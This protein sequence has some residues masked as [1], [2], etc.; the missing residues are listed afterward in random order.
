VTTYNEAVAE[1]R[2]LVKR[3]EDDQWR[4]AELTWQQ[5]R[6]NGVTQRQ[7]AEDVGIASHSY[8]GAMARTWERFGHLGAQR[9]VFSEAMRLIHKPGE[10]ADME[11]YGS[12]HRAQAAQAIRN[13]SPERKA[14]V[15][16]ELLAEPEVAEKVIEDKVVRQ[17]VTRATDR[18]YE[19]AA[20]ER[21]ERTERKTTEDPVARRLESREAILDLQQACNQFVRRV[22]EGLRRAGD[23]PDSE[24]FWF[25]GEV[26]RVGQAHQAL[27]RYLELGRSEID[28]QLQALLD[29]EV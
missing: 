9:P 5:L 15:A 6:E 23:L 2:T 16:R 18:H 22:E 29:S 19:K 14:E 26:N 8:V 28:A 11:E 13:L 3:S 24:R 4:L 20:A 21:A 10:A 1:A 7:W 25:A 17:T 27:Q 12:K